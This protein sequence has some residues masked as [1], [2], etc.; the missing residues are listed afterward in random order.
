MQRG[1]SPG[2]FLF[3]MELHEVVV[4]RQAFALGFNAEIVRNRSTNFLAP[5]VSE[6]GQQEGVA[7]EFLASVTVEAVS[8]DEFR[9]AIFGGTG[10][11]V[12]VLGNEETTGTSD[13]LTF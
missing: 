8:A 12:D 2:I 7:I 4:T 10:G 9:V 5:V 11:R 3:P 6:S 1:N 13:R